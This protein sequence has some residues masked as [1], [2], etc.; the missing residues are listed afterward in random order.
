[1]RVLVTGGFGFLGA[2][3]ACHLA[4]AGCCVRLGSRRHLPSPGW[5]PQAETV[6]TNWDDADA[7]VA[8]CEGSDVV[9]HAAGM[10]SPDC[11]ADPVGAL[12]FNGVATARLAQAATRAGVSHFIYLSSAHVYASPLIG[13]LDE[14]VCPRNLHPYASSHLAGETAV[15]QI[16]AQGKLKATVLRLSN[17]FGAPVTA[18]AN[19]W[20]LL[21]NDLCR[22]AVTYG[23]LTLRSNPQQQR[24]FIAISDVV[25][26]INWLLSLSGD[27]A[28]GVFNI[29][30]GSS[31]ALSDMAQI[32]RA[33]CQRTL[34][35][36]PEICLPSQDA[37]TPAALDFR[38]DRLLATGFTPGNDF[39]AEIAETLKFCLHLE[40]AS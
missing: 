15:L 25:R 24:D 21:F 26:A 2:R 36:A 22:E 20:M 32:I 35:F 31:L 27:G 34:G 9:V 39:D 12:L 3:L 6:W 10:N 37:A 38:I 8:A 16:A 28:Q 5:L 11:A 18:D 13:R 30:A 29:G 33:G 17:A 1:M 4:G 7:L 19:C 14:H 23:R 40:A